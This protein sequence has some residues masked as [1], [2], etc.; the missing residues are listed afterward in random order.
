M[1][2]GIENRIARIA[3]GEAGLGAEGA[4]RSG[5]GARETVRQG[6][7]F[8]AGIG[9]PRRWR[10]IKADPWAVITPGRQADDVLMYMGT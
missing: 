4:R 6:L 8:Q 9:F 2:A 3:G 1:R 7:H 5:L 10:S